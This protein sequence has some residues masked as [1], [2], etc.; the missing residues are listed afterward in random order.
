MQAI[1]QFVASV[2]GIFIHQL[3]DECIRFQDGI[4]HI[5][6]GQL[7]FDHELGLRCPVAH[8]VQDGFRG[9]AA[10]RRR[11]LRLLVILVIMT[12]RSVCAI[13]ILNFTSGSSSSRPRARPRPWLCQ[14][15]ALRT[16]T[17][18]CHVF[19]KSLE[20]SWIGAPKTCKTFAWRFLSITEP[21]TGTRKLLN[22]FCTSGPVTAGPIQ[23]RTRQ[24]PR[25]AY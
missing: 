11:G 5:C 19:A 24:G 15:R 17:G 9:A 13:K 16:L 22:T 23:A 3:T 20:P 7:R 18:S 21:R 6:G 10:L 2:L 14:R 8:G 4:G 12:R 25:A 1:T